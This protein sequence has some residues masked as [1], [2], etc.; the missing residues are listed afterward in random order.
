MLYNLDK[1]NKAKVNPS[2]INALLPVETEEREK[3]RKLLNVFTN[4]CLNEVQRVQEQVELKDFKDRVPQQ[5]AR[6]ICTRLNQRH[7][8][9]ASLFSTLDAMEGEEH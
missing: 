5:M 9:W 2:Q 4:Q 8:G 7:V 6:D 1:S 3:C